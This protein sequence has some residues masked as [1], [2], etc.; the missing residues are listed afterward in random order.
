MKKRSNLISTFTTP[1]TREDRIKDNQR[2]TSETIKERLKVLRNYTSIDKK[3]PITSYFP[4]LSE[5][6]LK[7]FKKVESED[8]KRELIGKSKKDLFDFYFFSGRDEDSKIIKNPKKEDNITEIFLR[9]I[10]D[11]Y[12]HGILFVTLECLISPKIEIN[13]QK[14]LILITRI[15]SYI[16]DK[17]S[18]KLLSQGKYKD[19][20]QYFSDFLFSSSHFKNRVFDLVFSSLERKDSSILASK[21][22]NEDIGENFNVFEILRKIFLNKGIEKMMAFIFVQVIETLDIPMNVYMTEISGEKRKKK[23][24]F[25]DCEKSMGISLSKVLVILKIEEGFIFYFGVKNCEFMVKR[26]IRETPK[27]IEELR[28]YLREDRNSVK[29]TDE[30]EI[31]TK[32]N[33]NCN[34][35]LDITRLKSITSN[36]YVRTEENISCYNTAKNHVDFFTKREDTKISLDDV[37]TDSNL[38]LLAQFGS[39]KRI[40]VCID[41]EKR[42]NRSFDVHDSIS[43]RIWGEKS[44]KRNS[45][46]ENFHSY[47]S[48]NR[49]VIPK[50]NKLGIETDKNYGKENGI[51]EFS[52]KKRKRSKRKKSSKKKRSRKKEKESDNKSYN[53]SFM[54]ILTEK[55][56]D[57]RNEI[58]NFENNSSLNISKRRNFEYLNK[59]SLEEDDNKLER[60]SSENKF[61]GKLRGMMRE[62][63]KKKDGDYA[64]E[65]N[66][67]F[68][69]KIEVIKGKINERVGNT[70]NL[71]KKNQKLI[72]NLIKKYDVKKVKLFIIINI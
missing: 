18:I 46:I 42:I 23:V 52:D 38:P 2:S 25:Y 14:N 36:Q 34:I 20:K 72:E 63:K 47:G 66:E 65:P 40:A 69:G 67:G 16:D 41:P 30:G 10:I 17:Y 4:K 5:F 9:L 39:T 15:L 13:T 56:R 27:T 31:S 12:I 60:D 55:K 64:F 68:F 45:F 70:E 37:E 43:G 8:L 58:S 59:I 19:L 49:R 22:V 32:A 29:N 53:S 26:E 54:K 21:L 44:V 24:K 1:L 28:V 7:K 3:A 6:P 35:P 51:I 61:Q 11:N 48:L 71:I 57:N 33:T 50:E 62:M